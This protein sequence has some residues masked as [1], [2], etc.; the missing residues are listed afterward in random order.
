[1]SA[2]DLAWVRTHMPDESALA[3]DKFLETNP[4]M[5]GAGWDDCLDRLIDGDAY[6]N[7][8]EPIHERSDS[9]QPSLV[10]AVALTMLYAS[11]EFAVDYNDIQRVIAIA[12]II[13][14][15]TVPS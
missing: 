5:R 14:T 10:T 1:M 6:L 13:D 7:I 4:H 3:L 2:A 9:P 11:R 12:V 15:R 8:T